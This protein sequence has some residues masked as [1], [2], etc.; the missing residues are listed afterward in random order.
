[1]ANPLPVLPP[2]SLDHLVVTVRFDLDA[3]S[4]LFERMGFTLTPMG[5]H[6]MG[7]INHLILFDGCYL[8]L[9]GVPRDADVQ[10]KEVLDAPIGIDSLV[11]RPD[12]ADAV[13]D[14]LTRAGYPIMPLHAFSRPIE[15][16]GRTQDVKFR[17]VR[18]LP[19][20]FAAGRFYYCEQVTPE[21][22]WMPEFMHHANGVNGMSALVLVADDPQAVAEQ[23]R[24]WVG[25]SVEV[26]DDD[27]RRLR[28][29][30]FDLEVISA[31]RYRHRFGAMAVDALGR[32]SYFGAIRMTVRDAD[33]LQGK[34]DRSP[35]DMIEVDRRTGR[36]L[37]KL[38]GFNVALEFVVA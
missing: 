20:T 7:S 13:F 25:A 3:A 21:L 26:V 8:E 32:S 2:L 10:R 27:A 15:R 22:V 14:A 24:G 1:M 38:R 33:R 31:N 35:P 36:T 16:D 19:G 12:S 17:T 30:D 11:L 6:A 4:A 37:V 18:T 9:I 29:D 34:L 5:R 23:Y 28:I